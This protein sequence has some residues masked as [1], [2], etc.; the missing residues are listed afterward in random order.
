[1]RYYVCCSPNGYVNIRSGPGTGYSSIG[2]AYRAEAVDVFSSGDPSWWSGDFEYGPD[3]YISKDYVKQNRPMLVGDMFGPDTLRGGSRGVYVE[4][5]QRCLISGGYLG[6]TIDGIFGTNT[7]NAVRQYQD[8]KGLE[9][10][11]KVGARTKQEL[12]L[13]FYQIFDAD[14]P[15]T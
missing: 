3:G 6:G 11:G 7:E 15:P 1:M 14:L 12:Y 5:L 13:D 4:H 10:D 8:D 9:S 2:R